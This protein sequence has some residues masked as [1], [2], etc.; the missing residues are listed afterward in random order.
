VSEA[1]LNFPRVPMRA[2]GPLAIV[3]SMVFVGVLLRWTVATSSSFWTDEAEFLSIARSPTVG[4]LLNFLKLHES[5]PPLFY[6]VERVWIAGL[7]NSDLAAVA[8]PVLLGVTLI[9]AVYLIGLRMFSPWVGTCAAILVAANPFLSHFSGYARP[10]SLLPLLATASAG[11]LWYGLRKGKT[12]TWITYSVVTS[13]MLLTHHWGWL[14]FASEIFV[15]LVWVALSK[16]HQERSFI[17]RWLGAAT[18]VL[19][20]YWWWLPSFLQQLRDAG[21]AARRGWT[22]DSP[23]YPFTEFA[24]VAIGVPAALALLLLLLLVG[25]ACGRWRRRDGGAN[26][27]DALA[28]AICVGVPLVSVAAAG[29]LSGRTWLT[30]EYCLLIPAPL[31]LLAASRGLEVLAVRRSA[32]LLLSA[33][34]TLAIIYLLTWSVLGNLG[35]SNSREFA[36]ALQRNVQPADVLL[37]HPAFVA[38]S[39]NYYFHGANAQIDFPFLRRYDAIPYDNVADKVAAASTMQSVVNTLQNAHRKERRVWFITRCDWFAFPRAIPRIWVQQGLVT[40]DVPLL[41]TRFHELRDELKALY[42]LPITSLIPQD[43]SMKREILCAE[44]YTPTP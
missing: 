11:C 44:L 4:A 34:A 28:L 15:T 30:P 10:Y 43:R 20:I 23:L 33:T 21:H 32:I 8:L 7:G 31:A 12:S 25:V 5:H 6:L 41:V 17:G 18:G 2:R 26:T 3:I 29:A 19:V 13:A 9:P 35:K 16:R 22:L 27:E 24:R 38:P 39:L 42:G 1:N 40:S 37:V 36:L 14:I